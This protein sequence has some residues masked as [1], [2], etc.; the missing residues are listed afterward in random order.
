MSLLAVTQREVVYV[1]IQI[2][3]KSIWIAKIC[4]LFAF[5]SQQFRVLKYCI[6]L[7]SLSNP[8]GR[9]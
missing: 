1:L 4:H 6:F 2:Q 5:V 8:C 7:S 3:E 9:R